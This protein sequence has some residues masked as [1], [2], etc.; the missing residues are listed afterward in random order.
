M[1]DFDDLEERIASLSPPVAL[2]QPD[3]LAERL[4]ELEDDSEHDPEPEP[5]ELPETGRLIVTYNRAV[6]RRDEQGLISEIVEATSRKFVERDIFG[7]VVAIT[8]VTETE[9]VEEPQ[10]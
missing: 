2:P 6:I 8:E 7:T 1:Q 9:E 3:D 5:E 4:R 10:E